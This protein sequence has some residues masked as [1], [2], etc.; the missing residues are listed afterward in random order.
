MCIYGF[1]YEYIY[2]VKI[3]VLAHE[4]QPNVQSAPPARQRFCEKRRWSSASCMAQS[5]HHCDMKQR[6]VWHDMSVKT[7]V[8]KLQLQTSHIYIYQ[9]GGL[10][11][12]LKQKLHID[13]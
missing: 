5:T 3:G 10:V 9:V 6:Q 7:H 2:I 13:G 1:K 12:R 11:D 8:L 4:V